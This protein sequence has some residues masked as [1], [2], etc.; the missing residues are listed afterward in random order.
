MNWCLGAAEI[1]G[2]EKPGLAYSWKHWGMD[3]GLEFKR[4]DILVFDEP[5]TEPNTQG[6][7]GFFAG[8]SNNDKVLFLAGHVNNALAVV[9]WSPARIVAHRRPTIPQ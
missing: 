5:E 9:A 6:H 8:H 7:A 2:P 1:D 4:G 3:A